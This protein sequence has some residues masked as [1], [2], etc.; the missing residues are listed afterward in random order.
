[1]KTQL[2][3]TFVLPK[4]QLVRPLSKHFSSIVFKFSL[5]LGMIVK[6][7]HT[8]TKPSLYELS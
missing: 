7:L 8:D 5:S 4:I 2:F 3:A 1:M 6:C